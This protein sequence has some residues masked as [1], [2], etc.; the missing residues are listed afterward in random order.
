M[1]GNDPDFQLSRL[2][3]ELYKIADKREQ[4]KE[5]KKNK[6]KARKAEA[7]FEKKKLKK[8]EKESRKLEKQTAREAAKAEKRRREAEEADGKKRKAQ[9]E[10]AALRASDKKSKFVHEGEILRNDRLQRKRS[11]S[12][13]GMNVEEEPKDRMPRGPA[14]NAMKNFLMDFKAD[15]YEL[16]AEEQRELRELE[17]EK[18]KMEVEKRYGLQRKLIFTKHEGKY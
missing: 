14:N 5:E 6:K 4:D 10:L 7:K 16:E 9:E 17:L 12:E 8:I 11:E 1:D 15:F 13:E 3:E 18:R 2:H